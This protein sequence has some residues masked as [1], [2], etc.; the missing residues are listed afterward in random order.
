MKP[1]LG[2]G[3]HFQCEV[4]IGFTYTYRLHPQYLSKALFLEPSGQP[5]ASEAQTLLV[6]SG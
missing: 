4:G 5:K 3:M 1:T 6:A 2:K